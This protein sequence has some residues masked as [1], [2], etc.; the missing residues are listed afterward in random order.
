MEKK[1]LSCSLVRNVNWCNYYGKDYGGSA[2]K[3]KIK[4][5]FHPLLGIYLK[6]VKTLIRKDKC[7]PVFI[8]ALFTIAKT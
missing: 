8:A 7:T 1:V 2:K 4:L 5:S 6:K 3:F